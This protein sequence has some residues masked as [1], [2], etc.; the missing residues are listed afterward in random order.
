MAGSPPE[1]SRATAVGRKRK[2]AAG[3]WQDLKTD[4]A[5]THQQ[6]QSDGDSDNDE[7]IRFPNE[8]S[9]DKDSEHE[10][11]RSEGGDSEESGRSDSKESGELSSSLT[12]S[13]TT[14][15]DYIGPRLIDHGESS[16]PNSP[17]LLSQISKD[18][19]QLQRRYFHITDPAA[20]VRCPSCGKEGHL[21]ED[22]PQNTCSHCGA[23]DDH[24]SH[25]CPT[26]IKCGRCRKRGHVAQ[27]CKNRSEPSGGRH[28]PCDVCGRTDH[29]EEECAGLWRSLEPN[30]KVAK[31]SL[32]AMIK[33][34]YNCGSSMHWGD[35]CLDL[36]DYIQDM[37]HSNRIWSD[38]HVRR[39]VGA[40]AG[41]KPPGRSPTNDD[42]DN[43]RSWQHAVFSDA[44]D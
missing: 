34:C 38:E 26:F 1:E 13:Q 4:T 17:I 6:V 30:G 7:Y 25:A 27:K 12:G 14:S 41:V 2:R 42:D 8:H 33:G 29:I 40:E 3:S 32:A 39:L 22:C 20:Y 19:Q 31:N 5:Q 15:S 24:F 36:P 21:D 43:A 11:T 37:V 16:Q 10:G 9:S 35:D 44:R 18:E 28:D 23:V